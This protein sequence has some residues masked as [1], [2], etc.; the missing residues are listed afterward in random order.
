MVEAI[1]HRAL[2]HGERGTCQQRRLSR[3]LLRLGPGGLSQAADDTLGDRR[4][5]GNG[6]ARPMRSRLRTA[7]SPGVRRTGY[8]SEDG[9]GPLCDEQE[10]VTEP[11][12]FTLDTIGAQ[13]LH[14]HS[15]RSSERAAPGHSRPGALPDQN[16]RGCKRE[17]CLTT[18]ICAFANCRSHRIQGTWCNPRRV[19]PEPCRLARF[20]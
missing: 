11:T 9:A 17:G 4:R 19:R 16:V 2:Q 13:A 7:R 12:G 8:R 1:S 6:S 14:R 10:L 20:R 18:R 15:R 3:L 5:S